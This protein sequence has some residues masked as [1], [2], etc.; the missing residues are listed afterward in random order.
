MH[1]GSLIC[2]ILHVSF[3]ISYFFTFFTS[4]FILKMDCIFMD[5]HAE[6]L[7]KTIA[8][9][10]SFYFIVFLYIILDAYDDIFDKITIIR[11]HNI[12]MRM[13]YNNLLQNRDIPSHLKCILIDSFLSK[14]P[15]CAICLNKM[16]HKTD[17]LLT[18]CG[19]LYHEE[20]IKESYNFNNKCP[21]CRHILYL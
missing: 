6:E 8:I 10:F 2:Y 4:Y 19:H 16:E 13:A 17:L 5:E 3:V 12:E 7:M 18:F 15:D 1:C 9:L 14:K 11:N 21:M 20:C